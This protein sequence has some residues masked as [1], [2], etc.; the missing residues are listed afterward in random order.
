MQHL[1]QRGSV[2][3]IGVFHTPR[4]WNGRDAPA[5]QLSSMTGVDPPLDPAKNGR[6]LDRKGGRVVRWAHRG[7]GLLG[8]WTVALPQEVPPAG[9]SFRSESL[10]MPE[11]G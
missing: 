8:C 4:L 9:V 5:G 6:R 1:P 10:S 11:K 3:Q 2:P 7:P